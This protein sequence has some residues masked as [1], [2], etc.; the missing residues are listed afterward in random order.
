MSMRNIVYYVASSIDGFISGVDDNISGFV[1]EGNGIAT[2]L[3][4][5]ASFDT[6]IMGRN[7]YEFGYKFGVQPGQPS[8]V[9]GHM[10]HYI[11]SDTLTF[12][13]K[14]EQVQVRKIQLAEIEKIKKMEGSDIYLCG[15]GQ[16]AGWLLDNQQIDMLKIKLSPVLIGQGVK[17]FG[18][19][20]K[21]CHLQLIDSETYDKGLQIMTFAVNY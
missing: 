12:D 2:Y 13:T 21:Q 19:S 9:Y 5:L 14:H 7:T 16:F 15:G 10:T 20:K 6:V 4:D 11:F 18:D 3:S 1:N 17:L 8:P